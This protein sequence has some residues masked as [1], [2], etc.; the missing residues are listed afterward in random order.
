MKRPYLNGHPPACT[1]WACNEGKIGNRRTIRENKTKS[2]QTVQE[3]WYLILAVLIAIVG[4]LVVVA[5][6]YAG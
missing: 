5:R 1:C 3:G 4:V 2:H 6:G